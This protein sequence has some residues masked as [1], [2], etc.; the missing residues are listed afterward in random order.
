VTVS[1]VL[2]TISK[3]RHQDVT[4]DNLDPEYLSTVVL[5]SEAAMRTGSHL[6]IT[7]VHLWF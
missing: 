3:W 5:E 7:T 6:A 4:P 2:V 1:N